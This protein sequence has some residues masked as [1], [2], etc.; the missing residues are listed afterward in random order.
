MSREG[1]LRQVLLEHQGEWVR[2]NVIQRRMSLAYGQPHY[3]DELR[4]LR[5]S[6]WVITHRH[7]R[8]SDF[9]GWEYQILQMPGQ[10]AAG[11]TLP[12]PGKVRSCRTQ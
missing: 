10:G 5:Q 9:V 11:Q 7:V 3:A 12:N 6:G 4:A 8:E 2:A 1:L